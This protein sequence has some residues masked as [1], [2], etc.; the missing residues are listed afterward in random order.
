[1]I[2]TIIL[3]AAL[4]TQPRKEIHMIDINSK[5]EKFCEDYDMPVDEMD[6]PNSILTAEGDR[7]FVSDKDIELME[8]IVAA[9]ARGES[10]E[11]Q[12]AV[13]TVI[14]N[15]WQEGSFGETLTDVMNASGQFAAPYQGEISMSVH[16]AVKNALI[17]YNT[18]CMGLPTEVL[19]FR[20]EHYHAFGVP[21]M[22]ID[23]LYFSCREGVII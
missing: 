6:H 22:S 5:V 11:A 12:E 7:A 14:L 16:L 10:C 20:S 18:Y 8:R 15:R 19:Y 9:E 17:Y 3:T 4:L 2:A 23:N 1:M 21:Y 13:A